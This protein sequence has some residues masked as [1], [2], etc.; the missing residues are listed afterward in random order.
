MLAPLFTIARSGSNIG[1]KNRHL[2][3]GPPGSGFE[4]QMVDILVEQ[5]KFLASGR[6]DV[7]VR[8]LG[9][10]NYCNCAVLSTYISL[11][12]THFF[13]YISISLYLPPSLSLY[14]PFSDLEGLV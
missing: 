6:E 5:V 14:L 2:N 13:Q 4:T 1:S 9:K 7:D 8:M 12:L 3:P 10:H 11:F